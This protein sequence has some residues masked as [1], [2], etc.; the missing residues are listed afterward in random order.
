MLASELNSASTHFGDLSYK[1]ALHA[2]LTAQLEQAKPVSMSMCTCCAGLCG[3][4]NVTVCLLP[5]RY[6]MLQ[7]SRDI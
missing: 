6:S 4:A 1:P 2:S 5:L 3:A 7:L